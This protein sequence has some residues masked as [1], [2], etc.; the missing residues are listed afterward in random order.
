LVV[1]RLAFLQDLSTF[2][3]QEVN[4]VA[5]SGGHYTV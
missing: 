1:I 5:G 3:I 2:P 4:G